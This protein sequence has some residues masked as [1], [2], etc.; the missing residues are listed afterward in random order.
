MNLDKNFMKAENIIKL[1]SMPAAA[2]SY[3]NGAFRFINREYLTIAYETDPEAISLALPEPLVP[4]G[5][6]TVIYEFI[7]MPDSYGFGDYTESGIVIPSKYNDENVNFTAQMYLDNQPATFGGREIWGFPKKIGKPKLTVFE[8]TLTGILEYANIQ[9]AIA[10]MTYKHKDICQ[11]SKQKD[12]V[13]EKLSKKQVNL[14]IIPGVDGKLAIAQLVSYQLTDIDIKGA[15]SGSARLHLI[16]HVN[17]PVADFPVHKIVNC[18]HVIADLTL[19]YG[20]VLYD[21]L[22]R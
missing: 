10:T 5:S 12:E 15:W 19:P 6:N 13:L 17:A 16:P 9:V 21:Y 11:D 3:P 8:D 4:D 18:I 1:P 14:K 7:R 20:D 2:P 22:D